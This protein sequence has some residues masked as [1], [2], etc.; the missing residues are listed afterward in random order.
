M[1]IFEKFSDMGATLF[2][3]G[4]KKSITDKPK[5]TK[6]NKFVVLNKIDEKEYRFLLLPTHRFCQT[7]KIVKL[8]NE[9]Y[10]YYR[11]LSVIYNFYNEIELTYEDL[12]NINDDDVYDIVTNLTIEKK[13]NPNLKIYYSDVQ[14]GKDR[15]ENIFINKD[16]AGDTQYYLLLGS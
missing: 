9:E 15:M 12:K 2:D 8:D 6:A 5:N 13:K 14:G 4:I 7:F 16:N 1:K 11:L 10:T 3:N